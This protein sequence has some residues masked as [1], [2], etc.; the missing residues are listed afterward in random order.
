MS[1][2]TISDAELI[3]TSFIDDFLDENGHVVKS[4]VRNRKIQFV[5]NDELIHEG[6]IDNLV[7]TQNNNITEY[8]FL[9]KKIF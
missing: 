1:K 2:T 9:G 3:V 8:D 5:L 7:I 4:R 6:L